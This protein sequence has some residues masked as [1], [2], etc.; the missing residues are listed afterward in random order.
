[1]D[2]RTLERVSGAVRGGHCIVM[3][4]LAEVGEKAVSVSRRGRSNF[5]YS[6]DWKVVNCPT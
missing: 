4:T 1:M 5:R 3:D 2:R 6:S